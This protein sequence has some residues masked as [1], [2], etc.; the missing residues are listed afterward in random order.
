RAEGKNF[1]KQYS[2]NV[3]AA[4]GEAKTLYSAFAAGD[5]LDAACTFLIP[6]Y[7]GMPT[8]PCA[9]PANGACSSMAPATTKYSYEVSLTAPVWNSHTN[10]PVYRSIEATYGT[11]LKLSGNF[12]HSYGVSKL[13]YRLDDGDWIAVEGNSL[14]V[15]VET[16]FPQ[17]SSHILVLRGTASYDHSTSSKKNNYNFLCAVFYLSAVQPDVTLS[18][19]VGN[20]VTDRTHRAGT[21]VELPSWNSPD[22][23]GWLGSDGTLLPSGGEFLIKQSITYRAVCLQMKILEGASLYTQDPQ[24]HLKFSVTLE[25]EEYD[26]LCEIS[27]DTVLIYGKFQ[28]ESESQALTPSDGKA[29]GLLQ[30]SLLTEPLPPSAYDRLFTPSVYASIRYTNGSTGTV[31]ATG[32][33]ARSARQVAEAALSDTLTTYPAATV[34]FLESIANYSKS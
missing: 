12:Y 31:Y 8:S 3:S 4:M 14:Q 24:P 9:D 10:A 23:V 17:D 20:T 27:E 19:Q 15:S 21:L 18:L 34:S 5:A 25:R 30:M 11:P 16:D 2:Q 26:M 28:G 22:F 1:W 29:D 13:E 7:Q 32:G 33:S 6:V